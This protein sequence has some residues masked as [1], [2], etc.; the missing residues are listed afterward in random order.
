MGP[1]Q[2]PGEIKDQV[3]YSVQRKVNVGNYESVM[4]ECG[5]SKIVEGDREETFNELVE[6][7]NKNFVR[8]LNERIKAVLDERKSK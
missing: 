5:G 3:W 1:K 7:M 8:A 6:E 4:V 2:S